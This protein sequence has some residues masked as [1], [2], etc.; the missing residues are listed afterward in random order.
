MNNLQSLKTKFTINP[1]LGATYA[2][3]SFLH[4]VIGMYLGVFYQRQLSSNFDKLL[5]K[6]IDVIYTIKDAV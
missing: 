5:L 6:L 3:V 1:K 4:V 2:L